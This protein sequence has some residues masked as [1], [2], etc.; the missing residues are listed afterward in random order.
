MSKAIARH[1]P[2]DSIVLLIYRNNLP[3]RVN[4]KLAAKPQYAET[5][6]DDPRQD[7]ADLFFERF[8]APF[9]DGA[10]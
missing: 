10:F 3:T 5:R 9:T 2:G 8:F 1:Q 7:D 6:M 4:V